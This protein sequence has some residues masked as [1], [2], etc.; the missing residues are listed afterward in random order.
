MKTTFK[1][2]I[3]AFTLFAVGCNNSNYHLEHA[4]QLK[5]KIYETLR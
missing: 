4:L 5:D 2:I 3:S 1:L